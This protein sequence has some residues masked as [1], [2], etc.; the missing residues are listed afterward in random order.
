MD[1]V[2]GK[3]SKM[4]DVKLHVINMYDVRSKRRSEMGCQRGPG[5]KDFSSC[6]NSEPH[7]QC[8]LLQTQGIATNIHQNNC[9]LF[10]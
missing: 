4:A 2:F 6:Y 3:E 7:L 9:F 8:T 1:C 10:T 5:V